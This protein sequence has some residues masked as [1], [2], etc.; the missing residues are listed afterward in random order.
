LALAP[1]PGSY[2]LYGRLLLQL[3]EREHAASAF[4]SGLSLASG[5][6]FDVPALAGPALPAVPAVPD[7]SSATPER[8]GEPG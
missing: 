6:D 1:D 7:G 5:I 4:R 2:A 3:G 8:E